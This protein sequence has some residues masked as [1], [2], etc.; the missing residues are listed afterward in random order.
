[1]TDPAVHKEDLD[2]TD[3]LPQLDLANYSAHFD[4]GPEDPL[5]R[6]DSWMVPGGLQQSV[7]GTGGVVEAERISQLEAELKEREAT[8]GTLRDH[9]QETTTTKSRLGSELDGIL[10]KIAELE[11]RLQESDTLN[12]RLKKQLSSLEIARGES[13]QQAKTAQQTAQTLGKER[14]D[15]LAKQEELNAQLRDAQQRSDELGQ[16]LRKQIEELNQAAEKARIKIQNDLTQHVDQLNAREV[17]IGSLNNDLSQSRTQTQQ[18]RETVKGLESKLD[19]Q[20]A[21]AAQISRFFAA[22]AVRSDVSDKDLISARAEIERL[23][24][25]LE[26]EHNQSNALAKDL[27][28]A[29][30]RVLVLQSDIQRLEALVDETKGTLGQR[31]HR[32]EE[33]IGEINRRNT[34]IETL[35][36]ESIESSKARDADKA[37]LRDVRTDLEARKAELIT[38]QTNLAATQAAR[39]QLQRDLDER[40]AVLGSTQQRL[41]QADQA[42]ETLK[43]EKKALSAESKRFESQAGQ[44]QRDLDERSAALGATQQRLTEADQANETLKVEKNA[45]SVEA[46]R[47]ESQAGQLQRDLD[48]RS[49]TL[50]VTQER[51]TDV[52]QANET[53]KLEREAL[54]AESL[55]FESQV[56]QL[57]QQRESNQETIQRQ[58]STLQTWDERWREAAPRLESITADL[59]TRDDRIGALETENTR[60][61]QEI[62]AAAEELE[63]HRRHIQTFVSQLNAKDQRIN[64]LESEISEHASALGTIRRDVDRIGSQAGEI[65]RPTPPARSLVL[66]DDERVVHLLNRKVMTI[67]RTEDNDIHIAS[68]SLS[69]R[70][71]KLLVGSNA[72][73][74]EDCD[75][76]NGSYLNGRRIK[77]HMLHDGDVLMLGKVRLQFRAHRE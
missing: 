36:N 15:L 54:S 61:R 42:N 20:V 62:A 74:V 6:T 25:L 77:R 40:S 76:T 58:T 3:E 16:S 50:G 23:T 68:T 57:E 1:M 14:V 53:L 51:L 27:R 30:E 5:S 56:Q 47:F 52:E 19:S 35:T 7:A 18:L 28:A 65:P 10:R 41:T 64:A 21:A 60:L 13:D 39:E 32:I 29:M 72:V 24:N 34:V 33:L 46:K 26:A 37:T 22:Q 43:V 70:H 8:L 49:A 63:E 75:S 69:R 12:A 9:L 31:D 38:L 55:R 17:Q 48:E 66:V 71:A 44:L 2:R 59:R 4:D 11:N 73:I 67:G 45:L